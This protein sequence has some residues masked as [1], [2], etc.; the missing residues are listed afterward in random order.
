VSARKQFVAFA[1]CMRAHGVPGYPDPQVSSSAGQVHV[2]I[3]PG[4]ANPNSPAF[5]SADHACHQL[6]PNGGSPSAGGADSAQ[7]HAQGVAF[8]DCMRSHGVPTFPDP[9]H[10]GAFDLPSEVNPQAP[11]FGR[12]VQA[13]KRLEPS[14]LVI[15]QG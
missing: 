4:S 9:D 6:L 5:Q 2:R 3:S 12:A 8:A 14:S 10:D 13:C 7:Q 15:N 11:H 1:T